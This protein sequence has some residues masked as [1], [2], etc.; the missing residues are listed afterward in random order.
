MLTPSNPSFS[1]MNRF[2]RSHFARPELLDLIFREREQR[3]V[4]R[5]TPHDRNTPQEEP[6]RPSKHRRVE[7]DAMRSQLGIMQEQLAAMQSRYL[8]LLHADAETVDRRSFNEF[9]RWNPGSEARF[10]Y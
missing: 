8:E 4:D 9:H 2:S 6:H 3:T 1:F 10:I 5:A 7:T